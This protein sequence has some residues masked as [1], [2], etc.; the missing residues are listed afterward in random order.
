MGKKPGSKT[1]SEVSRSL[2]SRSVFTSLALNNALN[3]ALNTLN[4]FRLSD[5]AFNVVRGRRGGRVGKINQLSTQ[6]PPL[7]FY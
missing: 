6:A 4:S 5:C 1:G 3:N 7:A 2:K